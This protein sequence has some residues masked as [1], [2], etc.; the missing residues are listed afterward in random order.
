MQY[1]EVNVKYKNEDEKT[2]RIKYST[3]TLLVNAMT[4]TESEARVITY[5]KDQ[6]ETRDYEI[7]GSKESKIKEVV[8]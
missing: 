2:G 1:F 4:V 7:T 3:E 6:G 8:K 5:L